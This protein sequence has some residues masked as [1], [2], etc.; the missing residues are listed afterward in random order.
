MNENMR[1]ST[2]K[3]FDFIPKIMG[4]ELP[5][6]AETFS[7]ISNDEMSNSSFSSEGSNNNASMEEVNH[8][9]YID[10]QTSGFISDDKVKILSNDHL[11]PVLY[12]PTI[13]HKQSF[14][15]LNN[16]FKKSVDKPLDKY[17]KQINSTDM[18]NSFRDKNNISKFAID[19]VTI[20]KKSNASSNSKESPT[21]IQSHSNTL[22]IEQQQ[23]SGT[24]IENNCANILSSESAYKNKIKTIKMYRDTL[25]KTKDKTLMFDFAGFLLKTG[26]E[27]YEDNKKA[28]NKIIKEGCYYLKKMAMKGD[29]EAQ[30]L[31]GDVYANDTLNCKN[32]KQSRILF[33]TAAKKEHPESAY[34]AALCYEKG[35]GVSRNSRKALT[36]FKF[37]ASRH[38]T[39]S[40]YKLG[41][42]Y[43]KGQM[44]VP[45]T[46]VT[47]QNG[48]KWLSRAV[49]NGDE[50]SAE[51]AYELAKI[52]ERGFLDIIIP[53]I[54]YAVSLYVH[55]S[56]LG[57]N[58]S[59]TKLGQIYEKNDNTNI[60]QNKMLSIHYYKIASN[61]NKADSNA[62]LK[63][64]FF[65]LLGVDNILK[66]D[67]N[68]AFFWA[69]KAANSE[70]SDAE[71]TLGYYYEKGIG[72]DKNEEKAN[73][74]FK[75]SF[76][77]GNIR[78]LKK[79]KKE[80]ISFSMNDS[81]TSFVSAVA[82]EKKFSFDIK[83]KKERII[84]FMKKKK[85]ELEDRFEPLQG[86]EDEFKSSCNSILSNI[87]DTQSEFFSTAL[88]YID[89]VAIPQIVK[90]IEH[91]NKKT[92]LH[93]KRL[94]R[95]FRPL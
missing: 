26:L 40:M 76:Q 81:N 27:I 24:L 15:T 57:H 14:L 52:H 33:E 79:L 6:S 7:T 58:K 66:P 41:I 31:L 88:P 55:A 80:D 9:S 1:L 45:K 39:R 13:A 73:E 4:F 34:R 94:K 61:G 19:S 11:T 5:G 48:I 56:S 90:T 70:N 78:A 74:W 25:L 69:E 75:K 67:L 86:D 35:I 92:F 28:G 3:P 44:G 18:N 84:G 2:F 20:Y 22:I 77:H 36:F 64:S 85:Q 8:L 38:H 32:L 46:V 59:N 93:S 83:V 95:M 91:Q 43:F 17:R 16:S 23:P 89:T 10:S 12:K 21:S 82:S 54:N 51:A 49:A 29:V 62:Q 37:A 68:Q 53:D 63:L 72:C 42:F 47:Q 87:I 71:Y 65:N 50:N 60:K 30:Y